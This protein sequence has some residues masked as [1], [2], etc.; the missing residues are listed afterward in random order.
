MQRA[1]VVCGKPIEAVRPHR[2]YCGDTCAKRAQ[3]AGLA[4]RRAMPA[5]ASNVTALPI[6]AASDL[7]DAVRKTLEAAGRLQSVEGQLALVLAERM[8]GFGTGGGIAALSKELSRAMD[9]A[10]QSA[11]P[12]DNPLDEL[13]RRRDAKRRRAD[14][15]RPL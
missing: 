2:K 7:V 5:P 13:R 3:R 1:C 15:P 14:D 10:L 8:C 11:L 6:E 9:S 12:P 4:S